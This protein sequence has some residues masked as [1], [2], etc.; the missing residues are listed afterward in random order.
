MSRAATTRDRARSGGRGRTPHGGT[1]V[2]PLRSPRRRPGGRPGRRTS[3]RRRWLVRA[4]VLAAVVGLACWVVLASPLLA[5]RTVQVDGVDTLSA[6][7]VV[8]T[9][10]IGRGTPLVRVDTAA[11][12][13]RVAALPQVAAVEVTRGWPQTVVVTLVERVPVAVVEYAGSRSLVD[14]DG[15]LFDTI[16]GA[17]PSGV[18]PLAVEDPGPDDAATT[19][20]LGALTSLPRDV[21][22]QV[23]GV[24][25]TSADDVRLT[26]TDGRVVLWGSAEQTDRKSRVLD[27]LLDQI[28][29][30]TLAPAG[31]LDV[32]TPD[33]VVLR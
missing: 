17:P 13:A 18:V 25:A 2:V 27:G 16:T 15:V 20:A 14:R 30:G 5:V 29:A 32:S 19:A 6:D 10:G 24:A 11:A 22:G 26:L 12:A 3:P 21:R 31:T 8:D 1:A 23:T 4:A 9:A 28:E 33:A 7:Q